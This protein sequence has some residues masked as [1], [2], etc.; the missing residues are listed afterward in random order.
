M[1]KVTRYVSE[2]KLMPSFLGSK[3][4]GHMPSAPHSSGWESL[5]AAPLEDEEKLQD[6]DGALGESTVSCHIKR[7]TKLCS[8]KD[9][10][11][12]T[13]LREEREDGHKNQGF[14]D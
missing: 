5:R 9:Q 12:G 13:R 11:C 14:R 1:Y 7:R 6:T 10:Q 8:G 3:A 4:A 2:P